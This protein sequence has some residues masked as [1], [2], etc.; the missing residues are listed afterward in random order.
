MTMWDGRSADLFDLLPFGGQRSGKAAVVDTLTWLV[1]SVI[2]LTKMDLEQILI[3]GDRAASYMHMTAV[4]AYTGP[5]V[6]YRSAPFIL[7]Q[8]RQV[9]GFRG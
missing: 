1:P 6:T 2:P 4:H 9:V 3:D 7:T 8:R 5:T